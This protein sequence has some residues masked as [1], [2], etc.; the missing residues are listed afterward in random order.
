MIQTGLQRP[1]L[2]VALRWRNGVDE[3]VSGEH[4]KIGDN[5]SRYLWE[6]QCQMTQ[7]VL[8][9]KITKLDCLGAMMKNYIDI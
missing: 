9:P 2:L 5:Y 1:K 6:N 3:A 8:R 7:I 4:G